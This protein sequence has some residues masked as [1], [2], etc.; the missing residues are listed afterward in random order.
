M[1]LKYMTYFT[2]IKTDIQKKGCNKNAKI[3]AL[4]NAKQSVTVNKTVQ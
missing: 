4:E 3:I 1:H 2:A